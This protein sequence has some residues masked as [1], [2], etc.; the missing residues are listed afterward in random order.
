MN[1]IIRQGDVLLVA[2]SKSVP[3]DIVSRQEVILAKGE[4]TG[5]AHRV[6]APTLYE[7]EAEGQHYIQSAGVGGKL[8]HEDHDPKPVTV[9]DPDVTYQ[10][11][12]QQEWDLSSQWKKVMD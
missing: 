9:L 6:L 1:K 4:L 2:V 12:P 11:I 10:V 8:Y 7:W 3:T 5:H